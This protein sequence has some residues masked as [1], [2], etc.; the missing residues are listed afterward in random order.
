M[1]ESYSNRFN[2]MRA[3]R[4]TDL[5]STFLLQSSLSHRLLLQAPDELHAC[6]FRVHCQTTQSTVHNSLQLSNNTVDSRQHRRDQ[7]FSSPWGSS[8]C[9]DEHPS[10]GHDVLHPGKWQLIIN[11]HLQLRTKTTLYHPCFVTCHLS[12]IKY[13]LSVTKSLVR[14]DLGRQQ[15]SELLDT[16]VDVKSP[17]TFNWTR[18][19]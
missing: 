3:L 14:G 1:I 19:K 12:S 13:P 9:S 16:V 11:N 8:P 17:S 18:S 7:Y 6:L 10:P 2:R 5:Y 15:S 4:R